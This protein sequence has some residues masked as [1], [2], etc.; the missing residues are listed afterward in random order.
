[1]ATV[2][3]FVCMAEG[4]DFCDNDEANAQ[5]HAKQYGDKHDLMHVEYDPYSKHANVQVIDI[6]SVNTSTY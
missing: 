3:R 5:R 1:M 6:T 4:C 2:S